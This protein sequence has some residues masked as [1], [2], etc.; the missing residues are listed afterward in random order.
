MTPA[1]LLA[2]TSKAARSQFVERQISK[3]SEE[4][5][6]QEYTAEVI[7]WNSGA[8][9]WDCKLD[10]GGTIVQADSITSG[11]E[12]GTGDVVSLYLPAQGRATITAMP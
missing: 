7:G 3:Q 12:F 5:A 6:R 2:T 11:G 9:A 8:G 4:Q 1:E 10:D